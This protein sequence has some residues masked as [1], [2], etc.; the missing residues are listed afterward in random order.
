MEKK[1]YSVYKADKDYGKLYK[2]GK[3]QKP[4]DDTTKDQDYFLKFHKYVYGEYAAGAG[5]V[6][7][8]GANGSGRT[9]ATL[10]SYGKGEQS[11]LKYMQILEDSNITDPNE[12]KVF[13][14]ISWEI[15][16]IL[17][18][19]RSIVKGLFS[20]REYS[21]STMANDESA[22]IERNKKIGI[23]RLLVSP[24][25][26]KFTAETGVQPKESSQFDNIGNQED[27]ETLIKMGGIRLA[28]EIEMKDAIDATIYESR[29]KAIRELTE[30]DIIDFNK[31]AL[32]VYMEQSTDKVKIK[33]IDPARLGHRASI[34]QDCRDIDYA[35]YIETKKLSQI[36]T[37]SNL[38]EKEIY[39]IA[40]KYNGHGRNSATHGMGD[41]F[42]SRQQREEYKESN[43]AY[44]YDDFVVDV[45]YMTFIANDTELL[46]IDNNGLDSVS[47][48]T[49][50][51]NTYRSYW[52]IGTD[53]VYDYGLERG[54]VRQGQDGSKETRLPII[55]YNGTGDSM[56]ERCI[57]YVNEIQIA[58]LKKRN[59]IRKI[60]PGPD[61]EVDLGVLNATVEI[62]DKAYSILDL[63]EVYTK[64]GVLFTESK[65]GLGNNADNRAIHPMQSDIHNKLKIYYDEIHHNIDQIRQVS[66]VNEVADGTSQTKDLLN[67]VMEGMNQ[68]TNNALFEW[69]RGYELLFE[70][71]VKHTAGKWRLAVLNGDVK[72][73]YQPFNENIVKT[74]QLGKNLTLHEMGIMLNI[75]P[76]SAKR[77]NMILG[78]NQQ[79][80]AQLI[81]ID[82]YYI[83][84]NMIEQGDLKKAQLYLSKA[85]QKREKENHQRALEVQ[86]AQAKANGEAG[87]E[88]EKSKQQTMTIEYDLK[89]QYMIAEYKEKMRIERM[90]ST[91]NKEIAQE[92]NETS[93]D[94][95]VLDSVLNS[96]Q[97]SVT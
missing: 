43:G 38:S 31:A 93:M 29:Y 67:G 68:A 47:E 78:L 96:A 20:E 1:G 21:V 27:L 35:Y 30:E 40:K 94:G 39:L 16:K 11:K 22:S 71:T 8:G 34:Y 14:N 52:P 48:E 44:P 19:F 18:K 33:Y 87:V 81:T 37:E 74:A 45:M 61:I 49:N 41:D 13:A 59:A 90:K 85:V 57:E 28:S 84:L 69:F 77:Q 32:H 72:V 25:V 54:I 70:E 63:L 17:P 66:G 91:T 58:T 89:T 26:K 36:R 12:A 64:D 53:I 6:G 7:L 86:T 5:G 75:L 83:L 82:V 95:K 65:G 3:L 46:L 92:N 62:N 51:Q 9:Y 60:P 97:E 56:V 2:S 10:R 23:E 4:S 73:K 76:D 24:L 50:L 42:G 79:R 88:V 55:I 80:E 15:V